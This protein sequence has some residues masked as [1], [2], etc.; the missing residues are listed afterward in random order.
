MEKLAWLSSGKKSYAEKSKIFN[1]KNLIFFVFTHWLKH[2][3][4]FLYLIFNI[5]SKK[6]DLSIKQ[7]N[8]FVLAHVFTIYPTTYENVL[9]LIFTVFVSNLKL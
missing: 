2:E 1:S 9:P 8:Y 4:A 6:I 3:K 5:I 7:K